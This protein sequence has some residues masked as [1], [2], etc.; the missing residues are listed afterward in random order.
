MNTPTIQE[1]FDFSILN[2]KFHDH[3]TMIVKHLG[4]ILTSNEHTCEAWNLCEIKKSDI[5]Q[6][7]QNT[8]RLWPKEMYILGDKFY[9]VEVNA[10]DYFVSFP[11]A[12]LF[13]DENRV[14]KDIEYIKNSK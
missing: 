10:G 7:C 9:Q 2:K 11:I 6:L 8:G 3:I 13:M 4:N 1:L 5:D 14:K 12:Y